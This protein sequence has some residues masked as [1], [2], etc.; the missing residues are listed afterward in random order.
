MEPSPSGRDDQSQ[1]SRVIG[2]PPASVRNRADAGGADWFFQLRWRVY[3]FFE[4]ERPNQEEVDVIIDGPE[5]DV[6]PFG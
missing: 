4:V 5:G 1:P 2:A 3:L 6:I